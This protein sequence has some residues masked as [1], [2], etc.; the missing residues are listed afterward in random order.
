MA[1]SDFTLEKA[2][3]VLGITTQ[4]AD[5]F[6]ELVPL[7]I[8]AW[9]NETLNK[10]TQLSLISE[11]ARSEFIIVPILLACRDISQDRLAIFSG[12]RLDIDP[13][14]G[15]IGECDF[16][17]ALA[18]SL[19]PLRSPIITVVEAK[20]NDVEAGLGQCIAQMVAADLFNRS[21]NQPEKPVYGC[22]TTG[23]VWQFLQLSQKIAFIDQQRY[24]L[25]NV[26][27]ILAIV[28]TI[29]QQYNGK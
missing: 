11:K 22:V 7:S 24:Y 28:Q 8:P 3:A 12:Q 29:V 14:Q 19:P 10:R 16:I 27:A 4:E 13:A 15:L 2:A 26:G 20:K 21:S 1:Y 18:P 17:L 6:P 5:L 23:E 9:L 25:D